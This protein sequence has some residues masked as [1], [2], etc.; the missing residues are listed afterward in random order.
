MLALLENNVYQ[1]ILVSIRGDQD[2][3][4]VR[5]IDS[6]GAEIA[7]YEVGKNPGDFIKIT[8]TGVVKD[9]KIKKFLEKLYLPPSHI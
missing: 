7:V 9:T 5:V 4:E 2:L 8:H 6:N 1:P 3:N